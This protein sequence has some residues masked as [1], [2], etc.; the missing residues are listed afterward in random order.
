MTVNPLNVKPSKVRD[1]CQT[2]TLAGLRNNC[3]VTHQNQPAIDSGVWRTNAFLVWRKILLKS[4]KQINGWL[5]FWHVFGFKIP[6]SFN[7][8]HLTWCDMTSPLFGGLCSVR[9]NETE[10]A[11]AS[12][13][14]TVW[15][16]GCFAMTLTCCGEADVAKPINCVW[17]A[18]NSSSVL[19]GNSRQLCLL[20]CSS[21]SKGLSAVLE[22]FLHCTC[23]CHY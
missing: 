6:C 4:E 8:V 21:F 17:F 14:R 7:H 22:A 5:L 3:T 2:V 18:G 11:F 10:P 13:S 15:H 20:W 19:L 12:P 1:L 16:A 23:T 9:W